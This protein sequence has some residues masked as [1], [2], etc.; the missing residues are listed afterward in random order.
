MKLYTFEG[1]GRRRI[2]GECNGQLADLAAASAVMV[3]LRRGKGVVPADMLE[4]LRGGEAAMQA[5]RDTLAFM[6]KRPAVP[7]GERLSYA[8]DEVKLLAPIPR[9]GKILCSGIN[10]HGHKEENPNATMP[11]EP[12]FFSKLPSAVIGPGEPI[13]KPS[14]TNQLDYEVEFAVV[15]GRTM[16]RTGE[17]DVMEHIAG[18]TILQ[19]GCFHCQ[20]FSVFFPE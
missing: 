16:K 19:T 6:A 15:I 4:F 20:S 17:T 8:F 11:T 12:F 7:V 9:P 2:G 10:Y 18:Y 13:V 14:Q 3:Q 1:E 5:G